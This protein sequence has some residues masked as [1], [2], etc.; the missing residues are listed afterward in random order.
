MTDRRS[1][2]TFAD[3]LER[4]FWPRGECHFFNADLT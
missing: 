1:R 3:C 4:L 2:K